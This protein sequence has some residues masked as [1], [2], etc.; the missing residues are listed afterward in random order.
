MALSKPINPEDTHG[1]F[2]IMDKKAD[3]KKKVAGFFG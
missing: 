2:Y 1:N 3:E